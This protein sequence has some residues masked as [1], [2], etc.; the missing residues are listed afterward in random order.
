MTISEQVAQR[1][2][3]RQVADDVARAGEVRF[4]DP[5]DVER[6]QRRD[7]VRVV[8]DERRRRLRGQTCG[9]A[10]RRSRPGSDR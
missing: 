9:T 6:V 7:A 4:V 1:E 10:S 2:Q 3:R 5:R 8:H